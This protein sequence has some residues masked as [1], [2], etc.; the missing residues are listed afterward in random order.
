[1][2]SQFHLRRET[3]MKQEFRIITHKKGANAL[4]CYNYELNPNV[5]GSIPFAL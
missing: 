5:E 4:L 3:L 1:M 2:Q